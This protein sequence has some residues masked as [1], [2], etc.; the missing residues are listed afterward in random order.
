MPVEGRHWNPSSKLIRVEPQH[1]R[2]TDTVPGKF[3]PKRKTKYGE[4]VYSKVP[5]IRVDPNKW[6]G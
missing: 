3:F 6:V 1:L 5:N 2:M 4:K